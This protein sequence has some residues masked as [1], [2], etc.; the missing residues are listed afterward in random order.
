[1]NENNTTFAGHLP[2]LTTL[3][4]IVNYSFIQLNGHADSIKAHVYFLYLEYHTYVLDKE[5]IKLPTT[6]TSQGIPH[7]SSSS[8]FYNFAFYHSHLP[9]PNINVPLPWPFFARLQR[10]FFRCRLRTFVIISLHL[11]LIYNQNVDGSFR[12]VAVA[13]A[14]GD[15]M[16]TNDE[17]WVCNFIL[18]QQM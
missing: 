11:I 14:V 9:L 2:M 4:T 15:T 10:V 6:L 18:T 17:V 5:R 1:M 3:V 12:Y 13:I 16:E 7:S 8:Q